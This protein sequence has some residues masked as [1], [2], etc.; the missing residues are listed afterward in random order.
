MYKEV[1]SSIK[2]IDIYPV[3]SFV[4]FFIFF[5][6]IATWLLRSKTEDF[7]IVSHLPLTENE[8]N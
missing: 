8:Q 7:E 2:N 3:F 1:L 4:V 5:I 6:I